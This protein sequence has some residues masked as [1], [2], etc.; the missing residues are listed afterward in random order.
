M[1]G[2][3]E[4]LGSGQQILHYRLTE[5]LGEGGM[6]VVWKAH[7]TSLDR[8]VAIKVLPPV[9]AA[10]PERL[11]RFEREARLLAS[12]SHPNIATVHSVHVVD[13]VR[14]LTM[15]LV[16]GEDLAQRI[17][18]GPVPVAE[19][20]EIARQ[21]A[22]A[23]EA[24]H[25]SGV[26]HRD[27]KPA[28]VRI[29]PDGRVKVLDF[30][31]AKA[32]EASVPASILSQSPTLVGTAMGAGTLIGTAAYMSPE[33]ARGQTADRRADIWA[34]GVVIYEMLTGKRA[35]EGDTVS[36]ILAAV[37]RAEPDRAPLPGE[38]PRPVRT[39]LDRC[40]EKDPRRR[41]RDIGEALLVLEDVQAGRVAAEPAPIAAPRSAGRRRV[42]WAVGV[43]AIAVLALLAGTALRPTAPETPLRKF[44]LALEKDEGEIASP[45]VSPDG[46]QI[47]FFHQRKLWIR[48]LG[49]LTSRALAEGVD[50]DFRP[51]WSPDAEFIVFA[52]RDGLSR[53]AI[54]SGAI[55]PICQV[56]EFSGG[57]GGAWAPD[58]RLLFTKGVDHLY[59]VPAGGGVPAIFLE[60]DSLDVDLHHPHRL[61]GDRG[62][63]YV[64]HL[65]LGGPNTLAWAKGDRRRDLLQLPTGLIWEPIYDPRGYIVFSRIGEGAGLW[66]LP[67]SLD[68]QQVTGEPFLIAP[69]GGSPSVASDGN[70][71]YRIGTF[72]AE[73]RVVRV[74]R[75]GAVIE[76]LTEA[77]RGHW[78]IALS[79]DERQLA[80]ETRESGEGDVWLFDLERKAETRFV[81]GPGR[82][83]E[84]AW[85][86]DGREVVYTEFGQNVIYAKPADGSQAPRLVARGFLPHFTPDGQRLIFSRSSADGA[87]D[88]WTCALGATSDSM[89]LVETP[90]TEMFATPS[91][92]GGHLLYTSDESGKQEVYLR[93]FPTGTGRWQVT[94]NGGTK[95]LWNRQGDRVYYWSDEGIY[96]VPI[97]LEPAVRLGTPR[98][99]FKLGE[100]KLQSWGRYNFLPTSNP[101]QFLALQ[102]T[103]QQTSASIHVVLVENWVAEF[104]GR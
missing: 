4:A 104:K 90:A 7:D 42:V 80:V 64:R 37:L 66:A 70:L 8:S 35:F 10:D 86:P 94:T 58:G 14:Y 99:L 18:R 61:P 83:G 12:L 44:T 3:P 40:L 91:P 17:A 30:G 41:L 82:Q 52:G 73:S 13:G 77:R 1:S 74:D 69:E 81:F 21:I 19:A 89:P 45:V 2:A 26:I 5:K 103:S 50:E 23:L 100:L 28:N 20:I 32:L 75:A 27:L 39:M 6:G 72:S 76:P 47:A 15:E 56:S 22:L 38:L 29:T 24:A 71:V 33:Q 36:D 55:A 63:L 78:S 62:L 60:K 16:P 25:E 53:V 96:E 67:F 54:S 95:G 57:A 11:A 98:L 31:L 88:L 79:P 49:Q 93:Q 102:L 9:F 85:S 97:E 59:G 46:R 48:D 65:N 34:F 43:G 101:D 51:L 87:V 68:R 84:P 92:R